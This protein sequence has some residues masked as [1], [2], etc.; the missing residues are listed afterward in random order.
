MNGQDTLERLEELFPSRNETLEATWWLFRDE[1]GM[2]DIYEQ[3]GD[4]LEEM[5]KAFEMYPVNVDGDRVLY[6]ARF[7]IGKYG[8]DLQFPEAKIVAGDVLGF[9]DFLAGFPIECIEM[10]MMVGEV[11]SKDDKEAGKLAVYHDEDSPVPPIPDELFE[12]Y[13]EAKILVNYIYLDSDNAESMAD[14]LEGQ[15]EPEGLHWWVR[16]NFKGDDKFPYPGEFLALGVRLMPGMV[17]GEQESSPFLFSGNWMDTLYYSN[18]MILEVIEKEGYPAYKVRWRGKEV[19]AM[20]TDF[21][22][23]KVGDRVSI[24]KEIPSKKQSQL[25]KDEDMKEFDK[26]KWAI[27]PFSFYGVEPDEE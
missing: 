26:E 19:E 24:L 14:N 21:A 17:W 10:I 8:E 25:W 13:E 20:P 4:S 9:V 27:A 2:D 5:F 6:L 22:E 12:G 18:A 23:Y 11:S 16:V 1:P 3:A 15:P 7:E